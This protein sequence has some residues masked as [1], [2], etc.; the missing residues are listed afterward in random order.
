MIDKALLGMCD[1]LMAIGIE[2]DG[3][4]V[5][6]IEK[7]HNSMKGCSNYGVLREYDRHAGMAPCF[8][9]WGRPITIWGMPHIM[10]MH[11]AYLGRTIVLV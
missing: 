8:H 7:P 1:E 6:K 3:Y 4:E 10:A 5:R 9:F 11:K 2:F